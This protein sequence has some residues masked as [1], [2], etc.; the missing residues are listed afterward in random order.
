MVRAI[1][2]EGGS[3]RSVVRYSKDRGEVQQTLW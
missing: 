2:G 3:V 1:C